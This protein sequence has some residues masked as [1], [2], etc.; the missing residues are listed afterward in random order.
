MAAAHQSARKH[1]PLPRAR[2]VTWETALL[3]RGA[4]EVKVQGWSGDRPP[5]PQPLRFSGTLWAPGEARDPESPTTPG[6]GSVGPGLEGTKRLSSPVPPCS[7]GGGVSA[8]KRARAGG[9]ASRVPEPPRSASSVPRRWRWHPLELTLAMETRSS[10]GRDLGELVA[11][12]LQLLCLRVRVAGSLRAGS[13]NPG[14]PAKMQ[15]P[16]FLRTASALG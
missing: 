1:Y 4:A 2:H 13:P 6:Y 3:R 16:G 15:S 8:P 11:W 10:L 7:A 14:L 12:P 5:H 9:G